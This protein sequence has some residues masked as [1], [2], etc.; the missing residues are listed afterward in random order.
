MFSFLK[1]VKLAIV[2]IALLTALIV[3][4]MVI[5]QANLKPAL[6]AQWWASHPGVAVVVQRLGLD[7]TF[8]SWWF[9]A[10]VGL[11]FVNT[12]ACTVDQAVNAWRLA[13]SSRSGGLQPAGAGTSA[14]YPEEIATSVLHGRRYVVRG[15]DYPAEGTWVFLAEKNRAG[16]WGSVIFHAGLLLIILG[17]VY[18]SLGR[19]EGVMLLT[20]GERR[21]EGHGEYIHL[22]E[23]PAFAEAHPGFEVGLE[24]VRHFPP[25]QKTPAGM[26]SGLTLDGKPFQL[27]QQAPLVYRGF[28]IYQDRFGDAVSLESDP[29]R[30]A[31]LQFTAGLLDQ[32]TTDGSK[33]SR[34]SL[35]IPGTAV[36]ARLTLYADAALKDGKLFASSLVLKRPLLRVI[37]EGSTGARLFQGDVKAGQGIHAA[38][39]K[40]TFTGASYWLALRIRRDPGQDM[41]FAGF[42]VVLLGLILLYFLIPRKIWVEIKPGSGPDCRDGWQVS[43]RGS[44][45]RH[46]DLLE[47]ELEEIRRKLAETP[48]VYSAD[49]AKGELRFAA[50]GGHWT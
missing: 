19:F 45:P 10:V 50:R 11:F 25:T 41:I 4:G 35:V 31:P 40:L 9:L 36:R 8:T 30:G 5:P 18:G 15:W 20:E 44:A 29:G 28:R 42:G 37:L 38:G 32:I 46:S 23:G 33:V 49:V 22:E 26:T 39:L 27:G 43:V 24:R 17:V 48:G 12:L 34:G 6:Y 21:V 7:H 13:W 14:G 3:A 2:L 16:Y 1:S 47:A